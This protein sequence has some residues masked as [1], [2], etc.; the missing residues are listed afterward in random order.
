MHNA[1]SLQS[2]STSLPKA[3]Y[4]RFLL[5]ED[6]C[7]H[8]HSARP[9]GGSITHNYRDHLCSPA[10]VAVLRTWIAPTG[11]NAGCS[12]K[13]N[14]Q[15]LPSLPNLPRGKRGGNEHNNNGCNDLQC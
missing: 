9:N 14:C 8:M 12:L 7:V 2:A 10:Q 15:P 5:S 13:C 6:F 3:T 11:P 4:T 1:I